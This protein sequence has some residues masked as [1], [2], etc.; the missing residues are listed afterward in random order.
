[1]VRRS[2]ALDT[3]SGGTKAANWASEMSR[4]WNGWTTAE[5]CMVF[6]RLLGWSPVRSV[7][8]EGEQ[9]R[10]GPAGGREEE[11]EE[12]EEGDAFLG[13]AYVGACML[14]GVEERCDS[15]WVDGVA[16]A[17]L[18][19]DVGGV[20]GVPEEE[21][22]RT[23]GVVLTGV[24]ASGTLAALSTQRARASIGS[25]ST[26][27]PLWAW[28][29]TLLPWACGARRRRKLGRALGDSSRMYLVS[30]S[31]PGG[32]L[33]ALIIAPRGTLSPFASLNL[34][35]SGASPSEGIISDV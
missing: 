8:G 21:R 12:E 5:G 2:F 24:R 19:S 6:D 1:M 10:T 22:S 27:V 20:R 29:V 31:K 35:T 16:R 33:T 28:V 34:W 32:G 17:V 11:E 4:R 25:L 13:E 23:D 9:R 30:P 26:A 7:E 3:C 14:A 18:F 15:V